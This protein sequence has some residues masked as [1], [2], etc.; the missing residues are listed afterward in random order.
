MWANGCRLTGIVVE[1]GAVKESIVRSAMCVLKARV[2][3]SEKSVSALVD[4][5]ARINT[6]LGVLTA[7]GW[8]ICSNRWWCHIT[9]GSMAGVVQEF[10]RDDLESAIKAMQTLSPDVRRKVASALHWI[11]EPRQMRMEGYRSDVLQ[12]YAGYRNAFEYLVLAERGGLQTASVRNTSF[13]ARNCKSRAISAKARRES[14]RRCLS[15]E[16]RS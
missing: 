5:G 7:V 3:V 9:H 6:L 11:R 2:A 4:A 8:G 12:T 1:A 14:R 16:G 15:G 10:R 13:S